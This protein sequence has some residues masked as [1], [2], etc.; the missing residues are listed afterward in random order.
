VPRHGKDQG[1]VGSGTCCKTDDQCGLNNGTRNSAGSMK[2]A[3]SGRDLNP[4]LAQSFLFAPSRIFL[5][6]FQRAFPLFIDVT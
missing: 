1:S 3:L 6:N 4:G 5:I 2:H